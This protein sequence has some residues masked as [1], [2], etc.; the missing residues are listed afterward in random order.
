MD[1]EYIA[2]LTCEPDALREL[3]ETI[4][5]EGYR[6]EDCRVDIAVLAGSA[7]HMNL[8]SS[9]ELWSGHYARRNTPDGQCWHM[10]SL[11]M[12]VFDMVART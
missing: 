5:R 3:H 7:D 4:E 9:R 8:A 11:P 2:E 6:E 12:N 1:I 10:L